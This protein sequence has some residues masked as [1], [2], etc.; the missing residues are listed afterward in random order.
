MYCI[1]CKLLVIFG[2]LKQ[3]IDCFYINFMLNKAQILI[4]I[5]IIYNDIIMNVIM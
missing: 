3:K 5:T 4:R 2:E 1:F